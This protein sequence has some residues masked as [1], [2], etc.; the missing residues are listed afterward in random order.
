MLALAATRRLLSIDRRTS[1]PA[2]TGLLRG[3]ELLAALPL[4]TLEALA[5]SLAEQLG[6]R[7]ETAIV[8]EG[9]VGDRF[10]VIASGEVEVA[11]QH[12]RARRRRSARSRSC[13]TCRARPP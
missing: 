1:A 9:E 10:Y 4:A 3:I 2:H 11:G 5:G 12:A 7:P 13:A 6:C 8:R